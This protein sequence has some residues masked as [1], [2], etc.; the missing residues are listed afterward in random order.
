MT[1]S[2]VSFQCPGKFPFAEK[3]R[4]ASQMTSGFFYSIKQADFS[5]NCDAVAVQGS[6]RAGPLARSRPP[7]LQ[8]LYYYYFCNNQFYFVLPNRVRYLFNFKVEFY[9]MNLLF[10]ACQ[11]AATLR[12]PAVWCGAHDPRQQMFCCSGRSR[13]TACRGKLCSGSVPGLARLY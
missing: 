2:T 6:P 7:V 4:S 1:V 10:Y 5:T 12:L 8:V 3:L 11:P 9:F 13:T